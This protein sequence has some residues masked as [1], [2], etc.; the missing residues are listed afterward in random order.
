MK[1]IVMGLHWTPPAPNA[2]R[3]PADLDAICVLLD[4]DNRIQE[5]IDPKHPGNANGSV[6]HTGDSNQGSSA[7]DDERIFVFFDALPKTV[8]T[9]A[10]LVTSNTGYP[11]DE[12]KGAYCHIS[13]SRK[14]EEWSRVDLTKLR[15]QAVC[16]AWTFRCVRGQ[17]DIVERDEDH[18]PQLWRDVAQQM[19][20]AEQNRM[21][22]NR[23]QA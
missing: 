8:K 5:I 1:E 21:M 9:V 22:A 23:S 4:A 18:E 16:L 10:F 20:R 13:D 15:G 12:V 14:D 11:F 2:T 17:W 6:V 19:G 3:P 7:W